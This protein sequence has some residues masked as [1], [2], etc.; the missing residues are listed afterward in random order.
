VAEL[1]PA[2]LAYGPLGIAA[3]A[4]TY[5]LLDR[6]RRHDA[7]QSE[8]VADSKAREERM[9]K[10]LLDAAA[11]IEKLSERLEGYQKALEALPE[12]LRKAVRGP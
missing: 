3:V 10:A 7:V 8:R 4:L 2:L 11:E 6:V 1:A 5:A 12:K 9:A